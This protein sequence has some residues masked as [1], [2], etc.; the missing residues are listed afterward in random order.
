MHKSG[1]SKA[2]LCPC[3]TVYVIPLLEPN[4][5]KKVIIVY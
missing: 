1:I 2:L 3:D 5:R 4:A